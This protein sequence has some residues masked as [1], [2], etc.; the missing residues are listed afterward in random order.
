MSL[1]LLGSLLEALDLPSQARIDQR[2]PK[3]LLIENGA[4]TTA[5]KRLIQDGIEELTWVAAL[6]P[7][8]IGVPSFKNDEREYLEI[9]VLTAELRPEAKRGRLTELLHRAVP[10]PVLLLEAGNSAENVTFSLANKRNSQN[11]AGKTVLEALHATLVPIEAPL[12]TDFKAALSL[13][14]NPRQDM[15]ALYQGWLNCL[16]A[17]ETSQITGK[18]VLSASSADVEKTREALEVIAG[19]N[20]ELS[21]AKVAAK[22]ERQLNRRVE[23]N[24]RIK[25]YEAEIE[26]IRT[27][28]MGN[29]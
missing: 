8:S 10:Y 1:G 11:E 18:F 19:L 15:Y 24:L 21:L 29:V 5:D 14:A 6:K 9:A 22:K 3:K 16:M 28:L 23:L 13:G 4:P 12:L 17:W 20:K 26:R 27:R 2:I 7:T 25:N